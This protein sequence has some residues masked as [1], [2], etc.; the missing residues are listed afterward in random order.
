MS[1]GLAIS[2]VTLA[3][4]N[5]IRTNVPELNSMTAVTTLPPDQVKGVKLTRLGR[6]VYSNSLNPMEDPWGRKIFWI[7]GGS[8]SWSGPEDSDFQ[9]VQN[10]YVS[11]TP[12]HLDLTH[13]DM[14]ESATKWWPDL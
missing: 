4:Q 8:I 3:L 9:A 2:A 11:V 12:L 7:G 6:R 5:L 10:G 14:L 1:T 13:Y